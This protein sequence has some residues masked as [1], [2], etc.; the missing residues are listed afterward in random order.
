MRNLYALAILLLSGLLFFSSCKEEQLVNPD[1]NNFDVVSPGGSGDD[2][3]AG[4]LKANFLALNMMGEP[5]DSIDMGE[6]FMLVDASTGRPDG[7]KWTVDGAVLRD[8]ADKI[9]L[10]LYCPV[11]GGYDVTLDVTRSDDATTNSVTM[12]DFV[13]VRWIPVTA[14]FFTDQLEENGKI[15]IKHG[16]MVTF[17]DNSKGL[18]DGWTWV[19]AGATPM[20]STTQS[21]TVQYVTPGT[22]DVLFMPRRSSD[23]E[24]QTMIKSGYVNVVERVLHLIRATTTDAVVTLEYNEPLQSDMSKV[25]DDLYITYVTA[26]GDL[27]V[28]DIQSV[29]L[30]NDYEIE[31][32]LS[33]PSFSDDKVYVYME[34]GNLYDATGLVEAPEVDAELCVYGHNLLVN[35]DFEELGLWKASKDGTVEGV[36]WMFNSKNP[37][38][39]Q[40][41]QSMKIVKTGSAVGFVYTE[42]IPFDESTSYQLSLEMRAE[43]GASG[44]LE[45]TRFN[46]T[47]ADG[48]VGTEGDG[49]LSCGGGWMSANGLSTT[50]W[51]TYNRTIE[52][53]TGAATEL[54]YNILFYGDGTIYID[55]VR[56]YI[57]NP[58]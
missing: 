8:S 20:V 35:T 31:V 9:S 38:P 54:Y 21:A 47:P 24:T 39:A 19:L 32:T 2:G 43:S 26:A 16:D 37:E 51:V 45:I 27:I 4:E 5:F 29:V 15:N 30:I 53:Y 28:P 33:E 57:D 41:R 55:N 36:D 10:P 14:D 40:G 22:Y 56:L 11:K 58:R 34:S 6:P 25:E 7:F 46:N 13:K 42:G 12:E 48:K 23:G 3:E 1:I 52:V 44:G 18:P 49:S 17:T 50:E